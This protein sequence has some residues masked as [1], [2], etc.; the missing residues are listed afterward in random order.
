MPVAARIFSASSD[1][2]A[3]PAA[4]GAV[5]NRPGRSF[6]QATMAWKNADRADQR[7]MG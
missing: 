7:S 5:T 1:L 2:T 3:I 6:A 4:A